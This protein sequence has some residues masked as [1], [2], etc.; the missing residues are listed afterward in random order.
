MNVT[1]YM[2]MKE[3]ASEEKKMLTIENESK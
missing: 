3:K 2:N 1:L